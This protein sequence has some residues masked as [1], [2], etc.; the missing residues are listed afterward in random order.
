MTRPDEIDETQ[1]YDESTNPSNGWRVPEGAAT[2][3]EIR[4]GEGW[5]VLYDAQAPG[6]NVKIHGT[7]EEAEAAVRNADRATAGNVSGRVVRFAD[8]WDLPDYDLPGLRK[9]VEEV[10]PFVCAGAAEHEVAAVRAALA[11]IASAR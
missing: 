7:R 5:L 1:P 3:E 8:A 11:K 4:D 6:D 2:P 9:A 10:L